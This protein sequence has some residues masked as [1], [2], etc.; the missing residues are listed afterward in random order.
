M[1]YLSVRCNRRGDDKRMTTLFPGAQDNFD[2]PLGTDGLLAFDHAA[3]H[4]DVNDAVEAIEAIIGTP[5]VVSPTSILTRLGD[6]ESA[7]GGVT[8]HGALTGLF[9]DDHTQYPLGAGRASGQTLIGG[10]QAAD[11]LTLQGTSATGTGTAIKMLCGTA[12]ATEAV[13]V[14]ESGYVGI[15]NPTPLGA[16]D[17]CENF[18]L[19]S[20]GM[21]ASIGTDAIGSITSATGNVVNGTINTQI[22]I[23]DDNSNRWGNLCNKMVVQASAPCN[24]TR[25]SLFNDFSV[26]AES[27]GSFSSLRGLQNYVYNYGSGTVTEGYGTIT[28]FQSS[29]GNAT[30]L[31]ASHNSVGVSSGTTAFAAGVNGLVGTLVSGGTASVAAGLSAIISTV[32]G[33]T[34]NKAIGVSI[35]ASSSSQLL[36][37]SA[38]TIDECYALF[39]G[40]STNVGTT[41]KAIHSA[42]SAQS[43]LAGGLAIGLDAESAKLHSVAP[44]EQLRLGYDAAK[45]AS[46]TVDSAGKLK[47]SA[48]LIFTPPASITPASN[49]DLVVEATS[50][51][52]LTFRLKG[53]DGVVR[54]ASLTLA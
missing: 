1:F 49:G 52:S 53:S 46:F 40:A 4:S 33:S 38:G 32:A 47:I 10:T 30:R 18:I 6:L 42:S 16:L 17:V 3:L 41:K 28:S 35:G 9:D 45:Y 31:Y 7:G 8:D 51:T 5:D 14:L 26:P 19:S 15:G 43:Y 27:V 36:W 22:N 48:P 50:N 24:K 23:G 44:T 2:N 25:Y 20:N 37:S 11:V 54:S 39:I 29:G 13:T 34:I 21:I 12:G